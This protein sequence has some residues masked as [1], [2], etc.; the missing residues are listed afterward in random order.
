MTWPNQIVKPRLSYIAGAFFGYV[1][2]VLEANL[3]SVRRSRLRF[4]A[5]H[6]LHG[7]LTLFPNCNNIDFVCISDDCQ[8]G[9]CDCQS[10]AAWGRVG[11]TSS[12]PT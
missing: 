9:S 11:R 6:V 3:R 5:G 1:V 12:P 7:N 4:C 2:P 10:Y 8:L